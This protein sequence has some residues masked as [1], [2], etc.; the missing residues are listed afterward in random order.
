MSMQEFVDHWFRTPTSVIPFPN[1]PWPCRLVNCKAPRLP[2]G[3][4]LYMSAVARYSP[5]PR[6]SF[7]C[8]KLWVGASCAQG[9][10]G[11]HEARTG[12]ATQAGEIIAQE[13][14]DWVVLII[15]GAKCRLVAII[16]TKHLGVLMHWTILSIE[17]GSIYILWTCCKYSL[18]SEIL[19]IEMN[20]S[21]C[22]LIL[23]TSIFIYFDDK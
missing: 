15:C 20:V 13:T 2:I 17:W 5:A 9:S 4:V 21:R 16:G 18:R 11:N 22:I 14:S 6:H 1:C 10:E 12:R 19:V 8:R 23:D 3:R 7:S